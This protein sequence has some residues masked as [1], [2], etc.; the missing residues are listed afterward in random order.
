VVLLAAAAALL[1]AIARADG[2]PASD[3]LATQPLFVPEDGGL[4]PARQAQLAELARAA[5]R[6]GFPVR[7]AVIA[8]RADLGS[9]TA[10]WQ[11]PSDYARF[12]AQEL[13][14][15]AHGTLLVV[16]PNGFGVARIAVQAAPGAAASALSGLRAPGPGGDLGVATITAL[17]RL[18]AHAGHALPAPR[19]RPT[20]SSAQAGGSALSTTG[21]VAWAVLAAGA[22]LVAGAW[23]ASWRARPWRRHDGVASTHGS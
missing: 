19:A 9:V 10:L 15:V 11:R 17:R 13:S 23:T 1:P 7:V 2:D 12:L 3:V 22:I 21:P 6:A 8:R 14:Q 18:A 4:S 20:V 5:A 16:M